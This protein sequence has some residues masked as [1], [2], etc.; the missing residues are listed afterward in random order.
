MHYDHPDST[1]INSEDALKFKHFMGTDKN[2]FNRTMPGYEMYYDK[3]FNYMKDRDYW[4]KL[5]LGMA[6]L[7][8]AS[9]RYK[10]ERDRARM[11][12]RMDGYKNIPG[13]HFHNRGG[14]IVLK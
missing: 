4:M 11:T 2:D 13:H 14:V 12:A 9:N 10:V 6:L 5:L 3:D 1:R 7:C 8:Y